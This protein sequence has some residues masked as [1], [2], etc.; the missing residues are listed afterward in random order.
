MEPTID[1][2]RLWK[3][4]T[5]RFVLGPHSLHGPDHWRRVENQAIEL[6]Q[7]S[8]GDVLVA[9]LFAVFHD[10]ERRNESTDPQHGPRAALLAEKMHGDWF[11]VTP[12]QL[13]L[14]TEACRHHT[15][16]RT[17][18]D[19]TIGACWDADRLDLPR[20]GIWPRAEYL[21]TAETRRRVSS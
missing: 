11:V 9:R 7:A 10:C 15:G 2:P 16:G 20:V 1:F 4:L 13:E 12:V 8:G 21:S 18:D 14:L 3:H 17:S 19:P 6:A 5:D